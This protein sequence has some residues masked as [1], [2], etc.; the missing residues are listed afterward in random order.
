MN[1]FQYLSD[2]Y[3]GFSIQHNVG[4]G[5]FRYM[6]LTRKLKLRQFWEAKGIVGGLSDENYKLNFVSSNSFQTLNNK[7]YLEIGTGV[8]NIF[9]FFAVDFIWRV[10][11][12][13]L[14]EVRSQR[15]G[16]FFGFSITL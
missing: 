8:D 4:S 14:P 7:M 2:R 9:K 6:K 3:A 11:P 1:R 13:P 12:T 15:F 10:L 5:L 16:I